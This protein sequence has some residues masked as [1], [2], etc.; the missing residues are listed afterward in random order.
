MRDLP[1]T[2]DVRGP[3]RNGC[4][5]LYR[6]ADYALAAVGAGIFWSF[7]WLLAATGNP[8]W[9]WELMVILGVVAIGWMML[10]PLWDSAP[11]TY[12]WNSTGL[13]LEFHSLL[14]R[15]LVQV[16]WTAVTRVQPPG[17]RAGFYRMFVVIPSDHSFVRRR[18][19][20]GR[21]F[22]SL[23]ERPIDVTR[24]EWTLLAPNIPPGSRGDSA[25][26]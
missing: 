21:L 18:G 20:S 11:V 2:Q 12:S 26:L 7:A 5:R 6:R 25:E 10:P 8:S 17:P 13:S 24:G 1:P 3:Y 22:F 23:G 14:G 15:G 4:Y 9:L 19:Q 16:P